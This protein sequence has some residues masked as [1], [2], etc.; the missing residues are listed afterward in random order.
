MPDFSGVFALTDALVADAARSPRASPSRSPS[1]GGASPAKP[2]AA[3]ADATHERGASATPLSPA[4]RARRRGF[5][6][7]RAL[8]L[9]ECGLVPCVHP[10]HDRRMRCDAMTRD[11]LVILNLM[12]TTVAR[13][14]ARGWWRVP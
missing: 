9:A 14:A 1:S 2:S 10:S 11:R 3:D 8:T 5:A 13:V 12:S 7:L 6:A 4:F